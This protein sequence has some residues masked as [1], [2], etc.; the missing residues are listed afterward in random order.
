MSEDGEQLAK[1]DSPREETQEL[2]NEEE[3]LLANCILD[4][5]SGVGEVWVHR[6][7]VRLALKVDEQAQAPGQ[8]H[9]VHP[10][11]LDAAWYLVP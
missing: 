4:G 8:A 10:R 6:P 7:G 9:P 1:D 2:D 5:V 3:Q 11:W